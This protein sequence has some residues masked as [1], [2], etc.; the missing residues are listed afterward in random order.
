MA[1]EVFASLLASRA[2]AAGK[3][4]AELIHTAATD[5]T[6]QLRN[7]ASEDIKPL[8]AARHETSEAEPLAFRRAGRP[9][10]MQC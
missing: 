6:G 9:Q 8:V 4:V 7:V 10:P 2:N 3:E 5:G 1:N